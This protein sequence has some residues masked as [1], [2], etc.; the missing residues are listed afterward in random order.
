MCGNTLIDCYVAR[1]LSDNGYS[2]H[3]LPPLSDPSVHMTK[4]T[5][6]IL[7]CLPSYIGERLQSMAEKLATFEMT[8]L[9][10]NLVRGIP[11]VSDSQFIV[12]SVNDES[13][14]YLNIDNSPQP[15]AAIWIDNKSHFSERLNGLQSAIQELLVEPS[16]EQKDDRP[17]AFSKSFQ[18]ALWQI[19]AVIWH[20]NSSTQNEQYAIQ[21][22]LF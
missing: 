3:I 13:K 20:H 22:K 19:A 12:K 6:E 14:V 5:P 1:V 21:S 17:D 4:L 7:T 15:I 2:V 16:N 18:S 10:K 11:K 9:S 8:E